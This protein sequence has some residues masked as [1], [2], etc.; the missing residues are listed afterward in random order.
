MNLT[1]L[2]FYVP[3]LV[4][5]LFLFL[6]FLNLF[7]QAWKQRLVARYMLLSLVLVGTG[8]IFS[9]FVILSIALGTVQSGGPIISWQVLLLPM[10]WASILVPVNILIR[11]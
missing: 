8:L 5:L 1:I 9:W 6:Y 2:L 11:R 10:F 7:V 3:S 4:G